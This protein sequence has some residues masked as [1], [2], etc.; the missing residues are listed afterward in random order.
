MSIVQDFYQSNKKEDFLRNLI[1]DG[2]VDDLLMLSMKSVASDKIIIL[3]MIFKFDSEG[4]F[5]EVLLDAMRTN[6]SEIFSFIAHRDSY[7]SKFFNDEEF[8]QL[9]LKALFMGID[10][11][12]I[13]NIYN[14]KNPSLVYKMNDYAE[15]RFLARREIPK[16]IPIFLGES[17]EII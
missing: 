13:K 17:Y 15:E 3:E 8:N 11:L 5:K 12:K 7:P 14:R 4:L 2:K 10:I 16:V 1:L 9:V 6:S